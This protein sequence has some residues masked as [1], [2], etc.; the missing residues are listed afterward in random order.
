MKNTIYCKTTAKGTHTFYLKSD[1][2]EYFL[3]SR[4]SDKNEYPDIYVRDLEVQGVA[5]SVIHSLK[6]V[7]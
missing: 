1:G 2:K 6:K 7:L 4:N 5:V 3:E